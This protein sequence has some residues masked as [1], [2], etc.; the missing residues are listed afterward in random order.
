MTLDDVNELDKQVYNEMQKERVLKQAE[1]EA[2]YKGYE[3]GIDRTI[4][5]LRNHIINNNEGGEQE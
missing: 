4:R 2:Y 5:I 1:I 3:K